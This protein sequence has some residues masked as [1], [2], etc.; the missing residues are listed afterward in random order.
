MRDEPEKKTEAQV[1]EEA[2]ETA[3]RCPQYRLSVAA[4]GQATMV[5]GNLNAWFHYN[6]ESGL[7][8]GKTESQAIP[9]AESHD[10]GVCIDQSLGSLETLA[11]INIQNSE[12][13]LSKCLRLQGLEES[14]ESGEEEKEPHELLC[15]V[16]SL[17][18][19]PSD[20]QVLDECPRPS[21]TGSLNL[22]EPKEHGDN[23]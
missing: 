5:V 14:D 22:G 19:S 6:S 20:Y 17:V 13:V 11:R 7:W 8:I 9:L 16:C 4:S 21:C 12:G 2:L 23:Q 10:L 18:F 15:D 1:Y 3:L